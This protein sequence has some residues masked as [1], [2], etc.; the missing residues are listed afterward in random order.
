MSRRNPHFPHALEIEEDY[1]KT[2]EEDS[3]AKSPEQRKAV[4]RN[5]RGRLVYRVGEMILL[6]LVRDSAFR[7]LKTDSDPDAAQHQ[8]NAFM[9]EVYGGIVD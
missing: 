1:I 3:P 4:G 6:H 5:S 7:T 2:F 9:Q 8:A